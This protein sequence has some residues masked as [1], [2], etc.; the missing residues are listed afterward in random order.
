MNRW[1]KIVGDERGVALVMAMMVLLILT[2][3]MLA[4]LSVSAFEPQISRNHFDSVRARHLAEAGIEAGFN[5]LIA[6]DWTATLTG[7]TAAAPWR[8]VAGLNNA[9]LPGLASSYGTFSVTVRNDF[10]TG[11]PR[12]RF[13]F[14]RPAATAWR[15]VATARARPGFEAPGNPATRA[16]SWAV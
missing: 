15:R 9:T 6:V 11:S 7:A 12:R 13:V 14:C 5:Q 1:Q 4:F 3:L 8:T 10:Q 16:Y 2:G